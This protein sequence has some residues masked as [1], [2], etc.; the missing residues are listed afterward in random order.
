MTQQYLADELSVLLGEL[1]A[2]APNQASARDFAGLRHEAETGPLTALGAVHCARCADR[3]PVLGVADAGRCG[4][5][6]PP[7]SYL[8]AT[9]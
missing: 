7:G 2:A 9:A 6:H 5:V 8:R 4:R 1:Q 3:R